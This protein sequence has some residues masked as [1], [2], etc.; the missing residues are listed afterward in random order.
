[1]ADKKRP[2]NPLLT[3]SDSTPPKRWNI[4]RDGSRYAVRYASNAMCFVYGYHFRDTTKMI[5]AGIKKAHVR[6]WTNT[7]CPVGVES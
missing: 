4:V 2:P 6:K 5:P 3:T 1:M 7:V